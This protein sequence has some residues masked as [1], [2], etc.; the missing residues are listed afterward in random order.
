MLSLL[1]ALALLP[2]AANALPISLD[3]GMMMTGQGIDFAHG[4]RL[5]PTLGLSGI[6]EAGYLDVFLPLPFQLADALMDTPRIEERLNADRD[7]A[8]A[9]RVWFDMSYLAASVDTGRGLGILAGLAA[10]EIPR[11]PETSD[12][13]RVSVPVFLGGGYLGRWETGELIPSAALGWSFTRDTRFLVSLRLTGRQF[14]PGTPLGFYARW[15]LLHQRMP[16]DTH[17]WGSLLGAGLSVGGR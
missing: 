9:H 16:E 11:D 6:V 13:K 4:P 15:E 1:T 14:I 7:L 5:Y 10:Y 8:G 2:A 17:H 3:T 12:E